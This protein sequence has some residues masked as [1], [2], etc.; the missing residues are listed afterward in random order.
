MSAQGVLQ[1]V[2]EQVCAVV[3]SALQLQSVTGRIQHLV[4]LVTRQQQGCI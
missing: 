3:S 1:V 4:L 2:A